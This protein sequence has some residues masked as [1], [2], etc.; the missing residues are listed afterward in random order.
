MPTALYSSPAHTHPPRSTHLLT[1]QI[2][3]M[4]RIYQSQSANFVVF[5]MTPNDGYR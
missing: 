5:E 3:G 1:S 4:L 2:V